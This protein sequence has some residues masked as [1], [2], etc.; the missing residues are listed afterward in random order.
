MTEHITPLILT[1]NEAPNIERTLSRLTWA[2]RIVVIDSF[3]TDTTCEIIKRFDQAIVVQRKFDSHAAQWNFGLEQ[4]QTPWVLSLDADFVLSEEFIAE[5]KNLNANGEADG[6]SAPIKYCIWGKP[7]RRSLCPP[8]LVLFRTDKARFHDEGHTQR[9]QVHGCLRSLRSVVFHDDR[10]PID[11]WLV[12]QNRYMIKEARF[13]STTPRNRLNLPD[14]VRRHIFFAP[15]LM[16]AYALVGKGLVLDG[17]PG[18]YYV[19]QRTLAETLL[20]LRLLEL[21]LGTEAHFKPTEQQ[22]K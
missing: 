3:S 21:K 17:R 22:P 14:R 5:V 7:L 2:K 16:F 10:K 4:I 6:F 15:A 20:S 9:V 1:F 11:R 8:H 18:W 12:D 19:F 13:L